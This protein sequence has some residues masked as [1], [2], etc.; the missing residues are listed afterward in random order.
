LLRKPNIFLENLRIGTALGGALLSLSLLGLITGLLAGAVIVSFR[1]VVDIGQ[2]TFLPEHQADNFEG[3]SW[4]GRLLLP[5]FGG[6]GIGLLQEFAHTYRSVGIVHTL[7][8]IAYS[9]SRLPWRNAGQQFITAAL[10]IICGHSVGREGPSAHLGAASGSILG[11]WLKLPQN[12][13]RTLVACGIAAAIAASF[14]TPLAGV[15]FAIEV[16]MLE[17]QFAGILPVI[18]AAVAGAAVTQGVFGPSPA[19]TV[20]PTKLYSLSELPALV[21]IGVAAGLLAAVYNQ[22]LRFFSRLE[23]HQPLWQRCTAGGFLVGLCATTAPDIMGIGYDTIN[24][25][26]LGEISPDLLLLFT[27]VKLF[28]TTACI[29][30]G[31][32]GGLIGPAL[33]IGTTAGG[34]LGVIGIFLVPEHASSLAMYGM[35]GMAAM[36]SATLQAPLT[37]LLLLLELTINPHILFPGMLAIVAANLVAQEILRQEPLFSML[38][39][40]WDWSHHNASPRLKL[41]L[42]EMASTIMERRFVELPVVVSREAAFQALADN[43][44]WVIVKH[45]FRPLCIL[46]ALDMAK[47]LSSGQQHLLNLM[48]IPAARASIHPLPFQATLE[49]ALKTLNSS[50]AEILYVAHRTPT[51]PPTTHIYGIISRQDIE[52]YYR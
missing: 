17:Y 49:E 26:L 21:L 5:T 20:P 23:V 3:L 30:L 38:M 27:L 11:Q 51:D 6:L 19:F 24:A 1:L 43:P 31:I 13:L 25:V 33:F 9:Q 18:F 34:F 44:R 35:V 4:I 50:H 40:R 37:A 47:A 39:R 48:G 10:A 41:R 22:L 16:I 15:V 7:E 32:P 46:P 52:A 8:Q 45:D 42:Q 12:A 14:N 29:G 2:A 36:L 28:A